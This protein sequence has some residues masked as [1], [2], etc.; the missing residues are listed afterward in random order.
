MEFRFHNDVGT[1]V[2]HYTHYDTAL[3][4]ILKNRSLRLGPLFATN[5]PR[6][7]TNW[8]FAIT[9]EAKERPTS[10]GLV[11]GNTDFNRIIRSG[12]RVLCVSEDHD[13]AFKRDIHNRAYGKP[14]MW[15]QYAQNHAGV[16]LIFEK[17]DL[18]KEIESAC[19]GGEQILK[20]RVEYGDFFEP[21]PSTY[22]FRYWEAFHL[23]TKEI[24][25]R[26]IEAAL[27]SH[28]DHYSDVFFFQKNKDWEN[29]SEFR[30]IVRGDTNDPIFINIKSSLR[31]ILVGSFFP[32]ERLEELH[33]YC[34]TYDTHVARI[35][36]INGMP[37]L[38]WVPPNEI[39]S[40][41]YRD[42]AEYYRLLPRD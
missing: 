11:Y 7:T 40:R 14:R 28:R 24:D 10:E 23:S 16:C 30:W 33:T 4:H 13:N 8:S 41:P 2:A 9:V 19:Q 31:A 26:G 32:E 3:D 12:C 29:E 22:S 39:K 5:D 36:W 34:S 42:I 38:D 1:Y 37:E 35:V 18:E 6:E 17:T 20:G 27:Q 25:E 21:S 15:A